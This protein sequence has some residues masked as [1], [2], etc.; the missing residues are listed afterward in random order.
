MNNLIIRVRRSEVIGYFSEHR[1]NVVLL[2]WI[3]K[4]VYIFALSEEAQAHLTDEKN[5]LILAS[6]EKAAFDLL[7]EQDTEVLIS[8]IQDAGSEKL[9]YCISVD[10]ILSLKG[11]KRVA[12]CPT[13]FKEE[14]LESILTQQGRCT[15]YYRNLEDVSSGEISVVEDLMPESRIERNLPKSIYEEDVSFS[16]NFPSESKYLKAR[17][18][19]IENGRIWSNFGDVLTS[20]QALIGEV[21]GT[22]GRRMQNDPI[23][24]EPHLSPCSVNAGSAALLAVPSGGTNYYH[25]LYDFLPRIE[26]LKRAKILN[27]EEIEFFLIQYNK[28]RVFESGLAALGIEDKKIKKIKKG[29]YLEFSRLI[30]PTVPTKSTHVPLWVTDFLRKTFLGP[31]KLS[32]VKKRIF[33]S[34]KNAKKRKIKNEKELIP[35]LKELNFDIVELEEMSIQEQAN[36]F[37]KA[38]VV[39]AS[40]GAALSNLV[41]C[42]PATPVLELLNESYVHWLYGAL[43]SQLGLNYSFHIVKPKIHV[44]GLKKETDLSIDP[45]VFRE[46]LAK[47]LTAL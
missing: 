41:F 45:I 17:V 12:Y 44:I 46:L 8:F 6:F 7:G 3:S 2:Q 32:F 1:K 19:I 5:S 9:E 27:F 35:I 4:R 42:D 20:D 40:H 31:R 15:H 13:L 34:R 11:I 47:F 22:F 16:K 29:D 37:S 18:F 36:C 33:V 14:H 38:E 10:E 21:S 28:L 24:F 26:L 25:F 30:V 39:V 43:A 23:F